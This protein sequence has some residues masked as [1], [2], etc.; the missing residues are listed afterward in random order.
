MSLADLIV[1]LLFIAQSAAG[2]AHEPAVFARHLSNVSG[3]D[4][5]ISLE[6]HDAALELSVDPLDLAIT[7]ITEHSSDEWDL[8][9]VGSI[10]RKKPISYSNR[11]GAA[12][13]AGLCQVSPLWIPK[14]RRNVAGLEELSGDDLRLDVS[15]NA[16]SA[17]FVIQKAYE[18]HAKHGDD[19][20]IAGPHPWWAHY[21]CAPYRE[22]DPESGRGYQCGTCGYSKRKW[23]RAR[24]SVSSVLTPWSLLEEHREIWFEFCS[25]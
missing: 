11:D 17:A 22:D 2:T 12:G 16:L 8:S 7:C 3:L 10:R 1:S 14:I 9:I 19:D 15:A 5:Q 21:K 23:K 18:S 25:S 24:S 13:E 20:P 4:E 6:I